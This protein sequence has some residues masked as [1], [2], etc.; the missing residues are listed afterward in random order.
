MGRS[1]R[2]RE[3]GWEGAVEGARTKKAV[4]IASDRKEDA[5]TPTPKIKKIPLYPG[6]WVGEAEERTHDEILTIE[7][8]EEGRL[9]RM[10]ISRRAVSTNKIL[11]WV[12][13]ISH[14]PELTI[15]RRRKWT[16]IRQRS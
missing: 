15:E 2:A 7:L 6:G 5:P 16:G 13:R 3:G 12:G 14:E 9:K 11:Y 4:T 10:K 1:S 8:R